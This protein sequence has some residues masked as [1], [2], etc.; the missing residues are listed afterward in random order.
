MHV[1]AKARRAPIERHLPHQ[2]GFDQRV[3]AVIDRRVRNFRHL[4]FRSDEY[5]VRRG[6]SALVQQHVINLL[7][8]GRE[9]KTVGREMTAEI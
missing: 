3:Q 1:W 7:P 9:T 2:A 4:L 5:L 6:M 8:L